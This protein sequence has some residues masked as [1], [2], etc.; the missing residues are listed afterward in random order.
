MRTQI[1][2]AFS[3]AALVGGLLSSCYVAQP[4]FECFPA[5]S[6]YWGNL[7]VDPASVVDPS[8]VGCGKFTNDNFQIQRYLPPGTTNGSI[9]VMSD[10]MGST[11]RLTHANDGTFVYAGPTADPA[12]PNHKK[13]VAIGPLA[14]I[15]P[16]EQGVCKATLAAADQSYPAVTRR[17][18]NFVKDGG[19]TQLPATRV[20]FEYANFRLLNT[21]RFPGTIFNTKL[22]VTI[23]DCK[24]TYNVDGVVEPV[25][26]PASCMTDEECSPEPN[27]DA[28]RA[29]GSGLSK[30]LKPICG[31]DGVCIQSKDV[32]FDPLLKLK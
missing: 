24:A 13:E 7:T 31:P 9:A 28:G 4:S 20:K 2:F 11:T 5:A 15:N 27:L 18:S 23:D 3:A 26:G 1:T 8:A 14:S 32:T 16:D 17:N 12:D 6:H 21:A 10:I 25:L 29:L 30:D 22:T 19:V